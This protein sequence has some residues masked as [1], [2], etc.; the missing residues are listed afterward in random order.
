MNSILCSGTQK[1]IHL[2]KQRIS[3][4]ANLKDW[5]I[6][7]YPSEYAYAK[8]LGLLDMKPPIQKV[9]RDF[10]QQQQVIQHQVHHNK[11]KLP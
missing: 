10:Q 1:N 6:N 3:S 4:D 5:K 8:D 2:T 7:G 9:D 11:H